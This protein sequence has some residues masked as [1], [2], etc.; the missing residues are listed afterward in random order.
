[1]G[2]VHA[3]ALRN[4]VLLEVGRAVPVRVA[5]GATAAHLHG[6]KSE[7]EKNKTSV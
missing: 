6:E 4:A 3:A 2:T 1:V 5:V 7:Q